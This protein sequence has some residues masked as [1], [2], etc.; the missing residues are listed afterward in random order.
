MVP[1]AKVVCFH[2]WYARRSDQIGPAKSFF[3]QICDLLNLPAYQSTNTQYP[4]P[5]N[6]S[7]IVSRKNDPDVITAAQWHPTTAT[8]PPAVRTS[9][10]NVGAAART[11]PQPVTTESDTLPHGG[12]A[13]QLRGRNRARSQD[14]VRLDRQ[15]QHRGCHSPGAS[16]TVKDERNAPP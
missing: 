13:R 15:V 16:S 8:G 9:G 5:N 12:N 6:P 3:G 10:W 4:I 2:P 11:E 7:M 1:D 14:G